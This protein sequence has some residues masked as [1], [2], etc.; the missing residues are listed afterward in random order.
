MGQLKKM[1][2]IQENIQVTMYVDPNHP[3]LK[4]KAI[5]PWDTLTEIM[6]KHW[7]KAGKNMDGGRGRRWE[8]DLYVRIIVLMVVEG[9]DY[10]K[11]ERFLSENAPA[12]IFISREE[13]SKPQIRDHSNIGRAYA[14]LGEEGLQEVNDVVIRLATKAGYANA[15]ILSA[16][17]TAQELP[18]GYPNEPGIMRGIAQRCSRALTNLKKKG[19]E[20]MEKGLEKAKEVI[21]SVK[22]YQLFAKGEEVK[23]QILERIVKEVGELIKETVVVTKAIKEMTERVVISSKKKLEMMKEVSE[24]LIPQINQ[25]IE[26]GIVAKGKIIHAGIKEARAIVR[27]KIGKKVEFG[28]KYL[29]NRIGGGYIFGKMFLGSPNEAKMPIESLNEYRRIYGKKSTPEMFTYDRGGHAESTIKRLKKEG[30]KKIGIQPKGKASWLVSEE[31]RQIVQSERG[32]ME[33]CIG[34]LKSEK[35]GFNKPKERDI[36]TLQAAGQR[37]ILSYNLNKMIRDIVR[38]DKETEVAAG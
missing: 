10:R 9:L 3:L 8:S 24:Q 38:S 25:W 4:L 2:G 1:L 12:R 21:R 17:T 22:E 36:K 18:I 19:V 13:D 6:K 34:T 5:L 32:M 29:I 26:T 11:T 31:D 14:A 20:G 23:K 33:G 7:K 28:F 27:K 15:R 30:V 16:D 35:Y 37:S